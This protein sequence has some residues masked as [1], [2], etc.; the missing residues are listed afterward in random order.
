MSNTA[1]EEDAPASV[2]LP[3]LRTMF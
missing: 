1:F 2:R 3:C